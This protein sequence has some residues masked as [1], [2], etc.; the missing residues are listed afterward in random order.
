MPPK[1]PAGK[2]VKR[3]RLRNSVDKD[4]RATVFALERVAGKTINEIAE[5]YNC[6]P[7][8]VFKYQVRA[9]ERGL[10]INYA[11]TMIEDK[12]LPLTLAVYE[13]HLTAGNLEAAQ[14][15]LYGLGILQR[16]SVIKH[17]TDAEDTL[18]AFRE[19]FIKRREET[20]VEATIVSEAPT[21][22][23][24]ALPPH[25]SEF[26]SPRRLAHLLDQADEDE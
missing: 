17:E 7:S 19:K 24:P 4:S 22:V 15:I 13:N 25:E 10:I 6:H 18:E 3:S 23:P 20:A 5:T 8:T 16:N 14:D 26:E 1:T 11:R 21:V 12:L 2:T 9:R